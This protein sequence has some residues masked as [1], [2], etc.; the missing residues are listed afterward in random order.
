MHPFYLTKKLCGI[1][2]YCS[3]VLQ[4]RHSEVTVLKRVFSEA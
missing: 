1:L 4:E 3:I 2:Y